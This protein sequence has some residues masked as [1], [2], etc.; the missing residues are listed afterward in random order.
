QEALNK[1]KKAANGSKI[2]VLGVAYKKDVADFRESPAFDIIQGL[3]ALGAD[4]SYLD[5]HVPEVDENG[6]TMRSVSSSVRLGDYDAV[7]I[8]TDH[9]DIDYERL[10]REAKI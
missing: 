7:V 6:V 1:A 4:V 9:S 2:L 5:P 3:T 8:V 10:A